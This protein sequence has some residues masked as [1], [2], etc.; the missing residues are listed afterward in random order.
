MAG[1]SASA[2]IV[3]GFRLIGRHPGVVL[4]WGL[5]YLVVAIVPLLTAFWGDLPTVLGLYSKIMQ[6]LMA[7]AVPTAND[8]GLVRQQSLL[9]AFEV[10]QLG[11]NL[12]AGTLVSCAVYRAVLEPERKAF[13]YLRVGLQEL[14]V[15]ASMLALGVVLIAVLVASSAAVGLIAQAVGAGSWIG[16]LILFLASC[17]AVALLIWVALRL[18]M[19]AP[20]SFAERRFRLAEAWPLTH[21]QGWRLFA[22]ALGLAS[23]ILLIQ[24]VLATLGQAL[25]VGAALSRIEDLQAFLAHPAVDLARL[26][27]SLAGLVVM[28]ILVSAL[29][30]TLWA[31]PFAEIYRELSKTSSA[32]ATPV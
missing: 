31:A 15:I 24:M 32:P 1:F 17:G 9:I 2:A 27:P 14:C 8:P 22:V 29:S 30:F 19:A 13:A 10:S 11:L 25:G 5:A 3:S 12:L 16:G 18:S 28:Q 23:L 6:S 26:A 21:G 4:I 20:M 7:G